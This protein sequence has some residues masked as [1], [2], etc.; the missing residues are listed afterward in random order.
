MQVIGINLSQTK[1]LFTFNLQRRF[2]FSKIFWIQELK[3]VFI[4]VHYDKFFK[5]SSRKCEN[6]QLTVLIN[7]SKNLYQA[8]SLQR[9]NI[10]LSYLFKFPPQIN[11]ELEVQ[12]AVE[13]VS[14]KQLLLKGT[15]FYKNTLYKN[16][17]AQIAQRL[18]TI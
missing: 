10:F 9:L 5:T 13:K 2:C 16:T 18:R 15:L 14:G 8:L 11:V 6:E 3:Q 17:E 1:S 12:A 7:I 4:F